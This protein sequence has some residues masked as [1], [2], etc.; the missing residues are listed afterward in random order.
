MASG[1]RKENKQSNLPLVVIELSSESIHVGGKL[2]AATELINDDSAKR[3]QRDDTDK[4]FNVSAF[5]IVTLTAVFPA[6]FGRAFDG[7]VRAKNT[8][9]TGTRF[10]E[11]FAVRTFIVKNA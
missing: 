11:F 1:R 10:Q 4:P 7:T 6:R 3:Q 5:H 8:A 2:P 9:I